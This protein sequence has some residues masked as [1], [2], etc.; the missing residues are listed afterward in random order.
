MVAPLRRR[1]GTHVKIARWGVYLVDLNP[2]IGTKPG[3]KRPC[4][5]IQ[6][7]ALNEAGHPSTVVFPITSK[8]AVEEG[9][10]LRVFLAKGEGGLESNSV[11]L[12]DQV[13]AWDN[14]RFVKKLGELSPPKQAEL[15]AACRDFFGW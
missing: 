2:R 13:L 14:T 8:K 9:Y 3:K 6:D 15:E 10:P 12:V 4:V 7:D 1:E 5:V 11:I